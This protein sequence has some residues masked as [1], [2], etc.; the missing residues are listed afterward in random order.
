MLVDGCG[1]LHPAGCGSA[2][3]LGIMVRTGG[4]GQ[5]GIMAIQGRGGQGGDRKVCIIITAGI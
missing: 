4:G 1:V 2:C 3:Q 5:L